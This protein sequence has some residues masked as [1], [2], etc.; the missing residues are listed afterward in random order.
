MNQLLPMYFYVE[1]CAIAL[2]GTILS[3][4]P[5]DSDALPTGASP[6]VH[7]FVLLHRTIRHAAILYP[8]WGRIQIFQSLRLELSIFSLTPS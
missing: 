5:H 6:Q 1:Y 7:H 2:R 4:M 8:V 3:S